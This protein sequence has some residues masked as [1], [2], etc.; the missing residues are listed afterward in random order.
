MTRISLIT[1][2]ASVIAFVPAAF[3][4]QGPG[5]R[6]V[7]TGRDFREADRVT[8]GAPLLSP[9]EQKRF[10]EARKQAKS[11]ADLDRIEAEE[12]AL[13]NQRVADRISSAMDP[14][15]LKDSE[16]PAR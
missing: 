11:R 9:E 1:W 4:Q 8:M 13:L 6:Y 7:E 15:G 5:V 3:A 2:V 10:D 14:A 12:G 16:P